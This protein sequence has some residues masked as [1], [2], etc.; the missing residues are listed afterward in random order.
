M[1]SSLTSL[2]RIEPAPLLRRGTS[3][4]DGVRALL[5]SGLPGLPVV[6]PDGSLAGVFGHREVIAALFPGYVGLLESA[7][8]VPRSIDAAL[9]LR[10]DC[11]N[12]RV[13]DWMYTEHVEAPED[14]SDVQLAE[15]F[16]HHRVLAIP[17][18]DAARRVT[19]LVTR[20]DFFRALAERLLGHRDDPAHP[21]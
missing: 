17:I 7:T 2:T 18:V 6:E 10:A 20:E 12:E 1:P 9:E 14:C 4:A 13:G 19:G 15:T 11:A 8:F 21:A 5:D 16:L 3:V